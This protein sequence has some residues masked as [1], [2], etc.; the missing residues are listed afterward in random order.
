MYEFIKTLRYYEKKASHSSFLYC[1]WPLV[2]GFSAAGPPHTS[3][4]SKAIGNA[5]AW[6]F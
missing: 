5:A 6:H 2:V 4:F 1:F 3:P